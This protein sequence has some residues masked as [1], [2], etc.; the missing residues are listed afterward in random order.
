[1]LTI[2]EQR[3]AESPGGPVAGP[4][5]SA[6]GG[7]FAPGGSVVS[8]QGLALKATG[9]LQT[10]VTLALAKDTGG[11]YETVAA[12]SS[13]ATL[14]PDYGRQITRSQFLQSHQYRVSCPSSTSKTPQVSVFTSYPRARSVALTRDGRMP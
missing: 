1:M 14:L 12:A 13:L 4:I 8:R 2:S 6:G 10:Q 3:T 7:A 9:A 5:G 11:R